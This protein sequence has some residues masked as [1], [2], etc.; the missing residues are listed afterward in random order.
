[1]TSTKTE[2]AAALTV[3]SLGV[4]M[5]SLDLFIVNLAFPSIAAEHPEAS[6]ADLSWVL[7]AYTVVFAAAL[8]PAGRYA[9]LLGR[10][11]LFA[12]G[13]LVFTV[14][15][16]LCALAPDV[17]LLVA[18]RVVQAVGAGL[19]VPTSL[20]LL[21]A[22]VPPAGRAKAIGTW[23]AIGGLAAALGPVVGGLLVQA[24]WRLVFWVNVPVGL[25][26]LVM[27]P[28]VLAES[29]D[30]GATARPDLLGA[31]LLAGAVGLLALAVVQ[32]PD[33]GWTGP[34]TPLLLLVALAGV[35]LVLV[36]SRSHASPVVELPLLRSP[37]FAGALL[38]SLAYYAGF[39]AFLLNMVQYLT[40]VW[41]YSP[42][43]AG[44]AIAPGP[45]MVL[46]FARQVA[47]R[48]VP[49]LGGPGRVAALGCLVGVAAQLLFLALVQDTPAYALTLLGPQ[50]LGGAGVGLV[51]PSLL[52][53]G[54]GSLPPAQFGTGSGLLNMARQ[55]GA[56][57]GVAGL[58]AV[59]A[60]VSGV[61]A[62]TRAGAVL[63]VGGF[64]LAGAVALWSSRAAR[65]VALPAPLP[66]S[67]PDPA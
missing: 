3:L 30:P 8:V 26:A 34:R 53:L 15:S 52:G 24:D 41:G 10:R 36:R 54:A 59:L 28:R 4:F 44:L 46:P 2:G 19:M 61:V 39:S 32:A 56:V 62:P 12:A 57:L 25:V 33:V 37:A 47:P 13:L 20:S 51:I 7:N 18:A 35:G 14:G 49:R 60:G 64:A 11:R 66:A 43:R 40:D 45:L 50:L 23:A 58:I 29:R 16:A 5:A 42:I 6:L 17:P 48:L 1:M 55:L 63:A 9:D 21:L 38:A 67:V 27:T 65:P 22:S 31:V